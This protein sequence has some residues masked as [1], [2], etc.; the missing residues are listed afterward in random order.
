MRSKL[1]QQAVAKVGLASRLVTLS[2]GA[3]SINGADITRIDTNVALGVTRSAL[4]HINIGLSSS[5]AMTVTP[6]IEES[7]LRQ[8]ELGRRGDLYL[9]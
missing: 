7:D 2:S 6:T 9:S 1:I 3:L 8:F 4:I 5:S